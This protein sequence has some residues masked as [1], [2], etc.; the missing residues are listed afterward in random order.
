[1]LK[2]LIVIVALVGALLVPALHCLALA[3]AYAVL[4]RVALSRF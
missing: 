2:R 4:G 1:M 3:A